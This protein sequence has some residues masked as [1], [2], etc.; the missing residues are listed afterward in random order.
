MIKPQGIPGRSPSN[1]VMGLQEWILLVI[2][3]VLWGGSFFFVGVIVKDV[4]PFTLVLARASLAAL[5][6]IAF[7]RLSG[8]TMPGSPRLWMAFLA[9]AVVNSLIPYSLIAWGQ[10]HIDSGLASILISSTPLFSVVL[11][12]ILARE[13]RMTAA[14]VAGVL[15]GLGGVVVLVGPSALRG[16][17]RPRL[18]Q[19]AVLGA[20]LSYACAGIYGRRFKDLPP[21]IAAAGQLSCTV[22][23]VAPLALLLEQPWTARP[24]AAAWAA[25]LGLGLLS[26]AVGYLIFCRILAVAGATNVML[27]NF[28]NPVSAL[29]LGMLVLHERPHAIVFGGMAC[30]FGGLILLD[31]RLLRSARTP[32][33]IG[34]QVVEEHPASAGAPARAGGFGRARRGPPCS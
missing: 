9:M 27:V 32:R 30:I 17:D 28:L 8:A 11:A 19:L 31:G 12:H 6:L 24:S 23:L 22:L 1:P 7:V 29:L 4:P 33:P 10:Q 14:R 34:G 25:L 21:L 26:T 13:E 16:L 15:L 18:G 3:S 5:T 20:A 2:L